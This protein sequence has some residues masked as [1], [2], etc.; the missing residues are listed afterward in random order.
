MT[1][2]GGKFYGLAISQII[3]LG[4]FHWVQEVK[5][6]SEGTSQQGSTQHNKSDHAPSFIIV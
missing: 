2:H 4:G 5:A 6:R 3:L 1:M